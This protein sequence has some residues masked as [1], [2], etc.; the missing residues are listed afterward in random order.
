MYLTREFDDHFTIF[1]SSDPVHVP[2][3]FKCVSFSS[4]PHPLFQ[5]LNI[6]FILREV[7]IALFCRVVKPGG[8]G[9]VSV[10]KSLPKKTWKVGL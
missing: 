4:L 5:V 2:C 8:G 7:Y 3:L 6:D 9:F 1:V 10:K